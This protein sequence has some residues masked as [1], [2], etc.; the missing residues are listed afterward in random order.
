MRTPGFVR[1]TACAAVL[2]LLGATL[3]TATTARA[4]VSACS[5][6]SVTQSRIPGTLG[7]AAM[8]PSGDVWAVGNRSA[9]ATGSDTLVQH[10]NGTAW[11]TQSSPDPYTIDNYFNGVAATSDHNAWAVGGYYGNSAVQTL[12]AHWSGSAWE[13]IPS[14]DP[15]DS[16]TS[17]VLYA[18]ADVPHS[19]SDAWAV[20]MSGLQT[21]IV[22]WDGTT[23]QTVPSPDPGGSADNNSLNGVAATSSSNAWAVG[24]NQGGSGIAQGIIEH[25]NGSAW[26][27]VP[28]PV[29][30]GL[31]GVVLTAVT[32]TSARNAWA[33]GYD[34]DAT[35]IEHWNGSAWRHVRSPD[36]G[37][38]STSNGLFGGVAANAAGDVAAVGDDYQ[39]TLAFYC[40]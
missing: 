9:S 29:P 26:Q 12:I 22:R 37:G 35:L 28:F 16:A 19:T 17:D 36:P 31:E 6:W 14:P 5:D 10:W 39:G 34:G 25:W 23:W 7:G 38:S 20:G 18:V 15:G 3:T 2:V 1:G 8:L 21:L 4:A 40:T 27:V 30:S 33:V 32:A 24:S 13:Q 11:R